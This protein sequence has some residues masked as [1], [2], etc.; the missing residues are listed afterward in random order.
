MILGIGEIVSSFSNK[1]NV[2]WWRVTH[3]KFIFHESFASFSCKK[4]AILVKITADSRE[5][6]WPTVAFTAIRVA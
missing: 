2:I 5:F 1:K 4:F 3:D 6:V